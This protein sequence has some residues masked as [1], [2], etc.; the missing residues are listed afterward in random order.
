MKVGSIVTVIAKSIQQIDWRRVW[1]AR[2]GAPLAALQLL[3]QCIAQ[4]NCI[5]YSIFAQSSVIIAITIII[6][7]IMHF[8]LCSHTRIIIIM[9]FGS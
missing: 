6:I 7:I 9:P 2:V 5:Q 4:P 3:H 1:F 8:L